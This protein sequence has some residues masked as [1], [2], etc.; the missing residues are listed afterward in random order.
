GHL[1]VT[2]LVGPAMLESARAALAALRVAGAWPEGA[3]VHVHAGEAGVP[4]D[5]PSAGLPL[6]LALHSAA[7][8]TPLRGDM[9]ATGE[10]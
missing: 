5:G 7:D 4:K 8:R 1:T 2:G 9:A 6:A 10:I 3:E